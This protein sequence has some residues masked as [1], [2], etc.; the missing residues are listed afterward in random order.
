LP[1]AIDTGLFKN[2][3]V[4]CAIL[5][6]A[7]QLAVM[8]YVA[9]VITFTPK[10]AVDVLLELNDCEAHEALIAKG[11]DDADRDNKD[12]DTKD[13]DTENF[14]VLAKDVDIDVPIFAVDAVLANNELKE[15]DV[16][17]ADTENKERELNEALIE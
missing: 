17:D 6:W 7:T 15:F 12:L 9:A 5:V 14:D 4:D 10:D 2:L 1:V 3:I 11:A 13:V 16:K 8:G